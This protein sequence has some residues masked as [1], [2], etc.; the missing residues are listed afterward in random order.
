M[1]GRWY[2]YCGINSK[3]RTQYYAKINSLVKAY[4]FQLLDMSKYEYAKHA[5][6]D[7]A[8]LEWKGWIYIDEDI[9]KFYKDATGKGEK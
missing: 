1:N 3:V 5:F 2:D 9:N 6:R 4:N 7:S 8:H